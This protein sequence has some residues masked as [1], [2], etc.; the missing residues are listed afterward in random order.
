MS[1]FTRIK[2]K[3]VEEEYL[4]QALT[5]LGYVYETGNVQIRGF[6]G[7]RRNAQIKIATQNPGYDIGFQK[8]DNSYQIVADWWGIRGIR[9]QEFQ[10][11]L[12][13]RY[14]YHATKSKLYSQGFSLVS[15]DVEQGQRLHLVLRRMA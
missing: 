13:Q 6:A 2:T 4:T 8:V 10:D 15:E 5:D 11:Q 1:H 3:M 7:I 9:Q 14:A 12:T